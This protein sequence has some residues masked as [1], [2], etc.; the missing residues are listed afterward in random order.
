MG[1]VDGA[2]S[3]RDASQ[4]AGYGKRGVRSASNTPRDKGKKKIPPFALGASSNAEFISLIEHT[5]DAFTSS[6][7]SAVEDARRILADIRKKYDDVHN[8]AERKEEELRRLRETIRQADAQNSM[9]HDEVFKMDDKRE[10]LKKRLTDTQEKIA[11]ALTQKK[12]YQHMLERIKKEQT[13]LKQKMLK[14]EQH[15]QRKNQEVEEKLHQSRKVHQDRVQAQQLLDVFEYEVGTEQDLRDKALKEMQ[16]SVATMKSAIRRRH[17]FE[18]WRHEVALEAANEAFNASAGRLRKLWAVE[19]L[20]GN[21]LQKIIYEQVE[22]SQA[23]EDGFQKIREVTG[24]TDVMDIVHKFLN[25][26]IEHEQLKNAVKEAESKLEQLREEFE[27]CKRATEG[28]TF[29]GDPDRSRGIL[30]EVEECE[31]QLNK[32]L[33]DHALSRDKVQRSTLQLDQIFRWAQRMNR[34]LGAFE[35]SVELEKRSDIPAYFTQ[36]SNTVEKFLQTILSSTGHGKNAK[37]TQQSSLAKEYHEQTRLLNDKDFIK[38]NCRVQITDRP[39]SAGSTKRDENIDD[40][41]ALVAQEREKFKTDAGQK[42]NEAQRKQ[43]K[44]KKS[45]LRKKTRG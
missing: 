20:A 22:K 30:Q 40:S 2:L 8:E 1:D 42:I 34:S 6:D 3:A 27:R 9:K 19:K 7:D 36:L 26:D 39:P 38:A 23:T 4:K 28:M 11:E 41:A 43:A 44:D 24:L 25:R 5:V 45:Q 14:M 31:L 37:K 21:C 29:D 17:D 15:L 13:V 33:K 32:A 16:N 35:D 10:S 18:R 12:V